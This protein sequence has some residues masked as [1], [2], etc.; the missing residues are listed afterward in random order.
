M[1]EP[2][3]WTVQELVVKA[4]SGVAKVDLMG[5]RGTTLCSMEEIAAM[6]GLIAAAGLLPPPERRMPHPTPVFTTRRK[7]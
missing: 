5:L 1:T 4:A 7:R 2:T 6:A 3:R